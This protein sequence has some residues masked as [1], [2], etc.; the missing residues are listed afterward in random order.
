M[1]TQQGKLSRDRESENQV[2]QPPRA[3]QEW[4]AEDAFRMQHGAQYQIADDKAERQQAS[5]IAHGRQENGTDRSS[6]HQHHQPHF[7]TG[8][9]ASR[10]APGVG[11]K[12][13]RFAWVFDGLFHESSP[14][15][16]FE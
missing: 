11:D 9:E 10:A 6:G 14:T 16:L 2:P 4:P 8:E 7:N 1:N 13:E 3:L 15:V 5:H 12:V